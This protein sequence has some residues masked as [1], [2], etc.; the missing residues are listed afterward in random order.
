M[1]QGSWE[2]KALLMLETSIK[3]VVGRLAGDHYKSIRETDI[4]QEKKT[5][6]GIH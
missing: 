6:T 1:A 5:L 4:L 2:R 3:R